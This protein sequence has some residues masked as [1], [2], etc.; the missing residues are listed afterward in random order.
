MDQNKTEPDNHTQ[1]DGI[2]VSVNDRLVS[3]NELPALS[4]IES[5]QLAQQP[6]AVASRA[7]KLVLSQARSANTKVLVVDD[8]MMNQRVLE[9]YLQGHQVETVVVNNGLEAVEM[10]KSELFDVIFMNIQMAGMDGYTATQIMRQQLLLSTPIIAMTAHLMADEHERC[11]AVGMNEYLPKPIRIHQLDD[12]LGRLTVPIESR[13][14][15]TNTTLDIGAD[16]IHVSFLDELL[17]D[18]NELLRELVA[19][20]VRDLAAYRQT[21][22]ESVEQNDRELFKQTSHKF[23][24]SINALAMIDVAKKLRYLETDS[25]LDNLAL[26]G[27]LTTVFQKVNEGLSFL[28]RRINTQKHN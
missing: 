15:V 6:D 23:R 9:G 2:R 24:S 21:L 10:L 18:D 4:S 5:G 27:E 14:N 25:T 26:A 11:L 1:P 8:N 28:T 3:I 16:V 7:P 12:V 13:R 19:L 22:F 20:F 17:N